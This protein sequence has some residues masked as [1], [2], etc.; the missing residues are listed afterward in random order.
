MKSG[1]RHLF[2]QVS[3]W[4]LSRVWRR[5]FPCPTTLYLF[6]LAVCFLS[7]GRSS[8]QA[9]SDNAETIRGTV[10]NSVTR[11]PIGRA[12][13]YC[14]DNRF[15]TLT[16]S[17]GRFE[18]VVP[19]VDTASEGGLDSN[20]P[21][22]GSAISRFGTQVQTRV[23]N[24]PFVLLARKPGFMTD[25]SNSSQ[26]L[27]NGAAKDLTLTLTPESLIVGTVTLPTSETPDSITLQ[28]FRQQVQDGHA[29]WVAAGGT[30]STSDG[31][32]RFAD[33]SAGTYKLVTQE[34]LDRDPMTLDPLNVDSRGPLFGYPPVYYRSS[35]DFGSASTIQLGAGQTE[36]VNFSLVKQSYYRI[37]VPVINAPE[38]GFN[39][40]VY[41]QGRK[42][43]GFSLGY[44]NA[45]H[46]I[47]GMLPNGTYTVEASSF[48]PGGVTGL[49]TITI[50]G[51]PIGGLSMTL[52]P[53]AS[54]AVSVKEEFTSEDHTG[55]TTWTING[56]NTVVKGPRRYLNVALET[57][58]EFGMGGGGT[59]RDPAKA[60]DE[61][62]VIEGVTAG[63]YWV[64]VNSSR[65]YPAS[66]RS[67]NLDLQHQPL[68]VGAGGAS[69][70][71]EITMRDDTA[72]INGTVE[73][74]T[75]PSQESNLASGDAEGWT[76]YAAFGGQAGARIYCIPL[77]D[78]SGQFTEIWVSPDGN[79]VSSGL[80]PGA[81]RLLAFD[82][83]QPELEYRNPEAMRAYDAKGP[84]VRL[85]GGQK[86]RVTLQLIST[87][88][89][90]NER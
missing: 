65:G 55:S 66:I 17:E 71:I 5:I 43:P 49:Q 7:G 87:S 84:V 58:D 61:V 86:E 72:E 69:S 12:L 31:Q 68:L 62:L 40:N 21:V 24:R 57:A 19:K 11:E 37:K 45:D 2:L 81:Y 29:Q 59:M 38:N 10:I 52:V 76:S 90:G 39:V 20:A 41:A 16:S 30:Q 50:K 63:R 15:A 44:N 78:S 51:A 70:P 35:S 23:S 83:A 3:D 28:I 67:G 46:A 75:A 36:T 26:N 9:G 33:L 22:R 34:L 74:V 60:G 27:Q 88:G 13:V 6:L 77:A 89:S 14:P 8:A 25:P 64:R 53:T 18:F 47:E 85:V 54:I 73:G 1:D 42:G 79:F 82:R 56:R 32:F 4:S 80:A 48:G